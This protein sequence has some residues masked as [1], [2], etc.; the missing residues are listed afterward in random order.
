[1]E[2][3]QE[4]LVSIRLEGCEDGEDGHAAPRFSTHPKGGCFSTRKGRLT[5][6]NSTPFLKKIL[7]HERTNVKL[8]DIGHL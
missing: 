8:A 3:L 5:E 4:A 1:M 7:T 6:M 2:R